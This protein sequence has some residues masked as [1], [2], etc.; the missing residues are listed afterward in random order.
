MEAKASPGYAHASIS[1]GKY[2]QVGGQLLG[3]LTPW[4][5]AFLLGR[6]LAQLLAQFWEF[7]TRLH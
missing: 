3:L 6:L 4:G 5:I 7:A 1:L 2:L